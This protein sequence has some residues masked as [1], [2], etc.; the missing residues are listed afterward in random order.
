VPDEALCL[1]GKWPAQ[2]HKPA[3]QRASSITTIQMSPSKPTCFVISPIG[4][5]D[6]DIRA[7]ADLALKKI[8]L[9]VCRGKYNVLRAD[10]MARPGTITTEIIRHVTHAELVIADLTGCNANVFYELALRHRTGLPFIQIAEDGTDLP[11]DVSPLNVVFYDLTDP[12][13]LEREVRKELRAQLKFI[14]EGGASL[15][16]ES[17]VS[18][19]LGQHDVG[20]PQ[21]V[22]RWE[23]ILPMINSLH[24]RIT[25]EYE[26]DVILTMSG[27]GGIAAM[28]MHSVDRKNV[29]IIYGTTFPQ[30]QTDRDVFEEVAVKSGYVLIET[31]KWR[32]YLPPLVTALAPGTRV[33]IF[34]DR[35][36]SGAT[37]LA[38]TRC[39]TE[40]G[41]ECRR[42][43]L[44]VSSRAQDTDWYMAVSDSQFQF[45][46]GNQDGR[47]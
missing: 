38:A 9:P 18:V 21:S 33:L 10:Q 26:P 29:P 4:A 25:R 37:Q 14:D 34:D 17:P 6:S 27:P 28:L 15:R 40:L 1:V 44:I 45:P 22:Y 11:F 13:A 39:L 42:A 3:S 30:K 16:I 31:D 35:V 7:R 43:A 12:V 24:R 20:A 47:G 19:A 2:R 46:W 5:R 23:D 41:V 36:L 8:V 32:V